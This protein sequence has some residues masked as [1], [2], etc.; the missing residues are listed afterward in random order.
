VRLNEKQVRELFRIPYE[1]PDPNQPTQALMNFTAPPPPPP[2]NDDSSTSVAQSPDAGPPPPPTLKTIAVHIPPEILGD[3][4]FM[5]LEVVDL[6]K[7][8]TQGKRPAPTSPLQTADDY[9]QVKVGPILYQDAVE[10]APFSLHAVYGKGEN[11]PGVW[12]PRRY[13]D[14]RYVMINFFP[15][16]VTELLSP[17]PVSGTPDYMVAVFPVTKTPEVNLNVS[18]PNFS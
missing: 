5:L 4:H 8:M 6:R 15:R 2:A 17:A 9:L 14:K 7:M 13:D 1:I 11:I 12:C 10:H 3:T 16:F 18:H